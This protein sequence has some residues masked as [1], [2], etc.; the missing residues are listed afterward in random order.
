MGKILN[1]QFTQLIPAEPDRHAN[2]LDVYY[3]SS[4][5]IH[6][7]FRNLQIKLTKEEFAEWKK[8][9][10]FARKNLG[11]LMKYDIPQSIFSIKK[12]KL[13]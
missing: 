4:D 5:L 7:N 2:K 9:F 11:E 13:M 12:I 1:R 8:G 3:T 10:K 6:I